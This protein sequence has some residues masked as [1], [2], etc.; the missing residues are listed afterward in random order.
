MFHIDP[1]EGVITVDAHFQRHHK[2]ADVADQLFLLTIQVSDQGL[3]SLTSTASLT[4]VINSTLDATVAVSSEYIYITGNAIFVIVLASSIALLLVIGLVALVI[5]VRRSSRRRPAQRS[6]L[7]LARK[8]QQCH[9]QP[10]RP[11]AAKLS[12]K[13]NGCFQSHTPTEDAYMFDPWLQRKNEKTNANS[14]TQNMLGIRGSS[15]NR[16][17][18]RTLNTSLSKHLANSQSNPHHNSRPAVDLCL[19]MYNPGDAGEFK[20]CCKNYKQCRCGRCRRDKECC[21][22]CHNFTIFFNDK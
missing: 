7:C 6:S 1:L 21:K 13:D 19:N 22:V 15:Q 11:P 17:Q 5:L 12:N 3:P 20:M 2:H 16:P 10:Q 4:L 9:Q 18:T 14:R 8:E